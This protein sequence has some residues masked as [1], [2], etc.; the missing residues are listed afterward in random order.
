LTLGTARP[1]IVSMKRLPV[2][3]SA[4]LSG[5]GGSTGTDLTRVP[6]G[7]WGGPHLAV[8]VAPSATE[9]RFDC[10]EGHIDGVI[11]VDDGGRFDVAGLYT[12]LGGPT[13]D[14]PPAPLAARYQGSTDGRRLTLTVAVPDRAFSSGP[15]TATLGGQANI[16]RCLAVEQSP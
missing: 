12:P 3:L 16:F 7:D 13:M 10:A 4:L 8:S 6:E 5:C 2:L 9:L 15:F 1:I 11:A 14:P